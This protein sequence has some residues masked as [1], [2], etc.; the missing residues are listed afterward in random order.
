VDKINKF[1]SNGLEKIPLNE[2]CENL[3]KTV[4]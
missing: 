1:I 4:I 2:I 3:I